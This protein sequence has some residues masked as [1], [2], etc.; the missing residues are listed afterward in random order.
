M[1]IPYAETEYGFLW[2]AAKITR[3]FSNERKGWV[4]LFLETPKHKLGSEIQIYVSKTGKIRIYSN[5]GEWKPAVKA[6]KN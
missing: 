5:D 4:T 6:R 2:G 1:K 3:V